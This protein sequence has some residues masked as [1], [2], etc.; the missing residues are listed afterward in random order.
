MEPPVRFTACLSTSPA[1]EQSGITRAGCLQQGCMSSSEPEAPSGTSSC[2][3]RL[4]GCLRVTLLEAGRWCAV[5]C[6]RYSL[7]ILGRMSSAF[8]RPSTSPQAAGS[9]DEPMD[10]EHPPRRVSHIATVWLANRRRNSAESALEAKRREVVVPG[11]ASQMPPEGHSLAVICPSPAELRS[12]SA[13]LHRTGTGTATG[14]GPSSTCSHC[15]CT[16]LLC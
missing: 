9:C 7:T 16:S 2:C 1:P 8:Q 6:A 4:T 13:K 3:G 14:T 12:T 15:R 11:Q 10:R 5:L